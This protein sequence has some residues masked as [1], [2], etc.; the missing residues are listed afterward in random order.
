MRRITISKDKNQLDINLIHQVLT[1]TYWAK[2]RTLEE[3]KTT[4]VNSLCYGIFQDEKQIGFARLVTDKMVFAYLM[5]V[6]I[7][8]PER[9]YGH[10]HKLIDHILKDPE[11]K[12]V[13]QWYL[14]TKDAHDLYDRFGFRTIQYQ[15]QIMERIV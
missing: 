7:I 12:Q 1:N 9:G 6:F 11:V 14:K 13:N 10:A 5:D 3:V 15:A 2:G 4:I 8:E